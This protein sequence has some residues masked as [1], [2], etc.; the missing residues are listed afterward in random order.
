MAGRCRRWSAILLPFELALLF[1]FRETP[2]LVFEMLL[3]VL[4]TPP[5]MAVFVAATVSR[6]SPSDAYGDAVHR[7]A[8]ADQRIARSPPS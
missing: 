2:A 7:H 8:A 1:V 6:S 4:L 3:V 5:F